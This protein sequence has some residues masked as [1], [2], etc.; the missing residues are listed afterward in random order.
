M[1][2]AMPLGATTQPT[3]RSTAN[4]AGSSKIKAKKPRKQRQPSYTAEGGERPALWARSITWVL[5]IAVAIYFLIPVYWLIV[6]STKSTGDLFSTPGL[7][8]ANLNLI[9]NIRALTEYDG[10]IFW[11]WLLNSFIYSGVGSLLMTLISVM[12]GYALAV[13]K[14]RG[15]NVVLA[16]VM[17]SMLVPTTVLAQPTYLLLVQLGMSNTMLGVLLP[18]LVYPFGVMLGFIFASQAVPVEILEAARIDGASEA[19]TFFSISSRLLANGAVTIILFAFIGTWNSYMLP[20]L[21]L[22]DVKLQPITVGLAGWN[23]ASQ[24]VPGL[25]TMVI[26][27]AMISV[28][29]VAIVFMSLQRFWKSG[30]A[31]G[32]VKA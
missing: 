5:M 32:G 25:Q 29:P 26:V 17:G 12:A 30:L 3:R 7:W 13:Y 31:A 20:L 4:A 6:A 23:Q 14:F 28:I 21:V 18:S 11:R 19:R 8:F 16:A 1:S 10:G 9:D 22:N 2:N 27:G 24:T 15:R